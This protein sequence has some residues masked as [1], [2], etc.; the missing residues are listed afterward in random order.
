MKKII[1]ILCSLLFI[2]LYSEAKGTIYLILVIQ[3]DEQI[4]AQKDST[5]IID[6]ARTVKNNSTLDLHITDLAGAVA[7]KSKITQILNQLPITA[8]D[9]VW[10]HYSG[11]GRNYDTWPQTAEQKVPLTWVY[12]QLKQTKARLT[13]TCFDACTF[14]RPKHKP[15]ET[16][17]ISVATRWNFLFKHSK[18]HIR[19]CSSKSGMLAYGNNETGGIFTN[20][21]KDAMYNSK[22]DTWEEILNETLKKT[23]STA[24]YLGKRQE[25]K[26][27]LS[28]GFNDTG[29]F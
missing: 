1:I 10:F 14:G 23:K 27:E 22:L 19:I 20:S 29:H 11:H 18:G 2:N 24:K 26:Y 9:V 12:R 25:A 16:N 6:L 4:G 15:V 3:D 28:T 21:F 5:A 17:K 7:S 8:D 13:L